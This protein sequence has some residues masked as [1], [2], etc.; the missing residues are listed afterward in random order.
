[1]KNLGLLLALAIV[2]VS[3]DI[4][5]SR[6][7]KDQEERSS[8]YKRIFARKVLR[9]DSIY[10]P[11]SNYE[12]AQ[13]YGPVSVGTPSQNFLVIFDTGSSN[14]WVPSMA[15]TSLACKLHKKY[16][17]SKSSTYVAN[18]TA[19]SIQYGSGAVKG[20][21]S[22]DTVT[23]G[24]VQV[25]NSLFA[26]ITSE[27]GISFDAAKFDGILG[28]AWP[29]ISVNGI[30]PVFQNLFAQ[31]AV[32]DNSFAFYLTKQAGQAGSVL[33]LGGY[34]N[35]LSKND[36][37]YVPVIAQDYWRIEINMITV[38]TKRINI[39]GIRGIVDSGTSLLVG[40]LVLVEEI[41][42]QIGTVNSNCSNID[43]LPNVTLNLGGINYVMTPTDY[44]LELTSQGQNQCINGFDATVFPSQLS[45]T[46]ILG[47]LFIRKFYTHFDF[48][49]ARVGFATA[50]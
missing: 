31:G 16:D 29:A 15:C 39:P 25:A 1:M 9:G 8:F 10:V 50:L 48:G 22:Q 26:E 2:C 6:V 35:T 38:G 34:N 19:F 49:N 30:T 43:S 33:T 47:D 5:L 36:W 37:N 44:V 11:I 46:L 7:Y 27:S 21:T 12:D 24:G 41:K 45:N 42:G 23:W 17:H 3:V 32:P 28:M 40:S 4:P 14:L 13:Y 18:G 20:F